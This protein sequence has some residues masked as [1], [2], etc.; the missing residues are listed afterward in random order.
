M[1]QKVANEQDWLDSKLMLTVV[2]VEIASA[3]LLA[4]PTTVPLLQNT[5]CSNKQSD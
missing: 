4:L 2:D 1:M 5:P 3:I